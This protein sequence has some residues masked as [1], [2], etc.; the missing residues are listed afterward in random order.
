MI[1]AK[2]TM[3][4][5]ELF[6]DSLKA[7]REE[8]VTAALTIF[9]LEKFSD[10]GNLGT[11]NSAN[12]YRA[13]RV[14]LERGSDEFQPNLATDNGRG[15][16]KSAQGHGI[17]LGI[18]E[19]VKRG[20]AGMHPARHLDLGQAFL[21]HR[22]RNLAGNDPFDRGGANSLIE[23]FLAKPAVESRSDI[24]LFHDSVPI[25]RFS[26]R[27]I[28]C[29]GVFFV[30]FM[31]HAGAPYN[32]SRQKKSRGRFDRAASCFGLPTARGRA[33]VPAAYQ[34]ATKTRHP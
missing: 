10:S 20:S 21:L 32:L 5:E 4:Y 15:F 33:S 1:T 30:F 7:E 24:L 18:K 12:R 25:F 14:S 6:T 22:S 23:A 3:A 31:K 29:L 17:V 26:A 28:S 13:D 8:D 34:S 9:A 2:E 27:S 19:P 11:G 16:L